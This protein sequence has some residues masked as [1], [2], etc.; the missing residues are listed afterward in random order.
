MLWW[1]WL[2]GGLVLFVVELVTPS[3]FFIMFFGVGALVVGMLMW[4]DVIVS[5]PVQWLLFT[6]ASLVSL[7]LFRG[8]VQKR[9]Q[10][11]PRATVDSLVGDLAVP[12]TPIAPGA[13]GRVEVRGTMWTARNEAAVVLDTGQRCR[14]IR[15]T[16]LE[17]GVVPEQ[18]ADSRQ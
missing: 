10:D 16:E 6:V 1:H 2:A 8:R 12:Q 4:A 17:L 15:I 7:A 14:V 11:P 5:A 18:A 3:G 9:L 13:I